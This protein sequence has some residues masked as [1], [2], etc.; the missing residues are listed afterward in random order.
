MEL[1]APILV[2]GLFPELDV[3]VIELLGSLTAEDWY[4]PT[5][6]RF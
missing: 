3:C 2:A 6:A 1:S 5:V 4:R